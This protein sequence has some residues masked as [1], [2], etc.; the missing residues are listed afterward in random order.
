MNDLFYENRGN[1]D[2]HLLNKE[3]TYAFFSKYA[4]RDFNNFEQIIAA[5]C[6][7]FIDNETFIR[8]Y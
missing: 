6:M 1:I 3:A 8:F 5:L 4:H 2:R 7:P